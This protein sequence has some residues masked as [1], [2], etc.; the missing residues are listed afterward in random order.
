MYQVKKDWL[1]SI[2]VVC[3]V[4][5]A[6]LALQFTTRQQ[7][8]DISGY[9]RAD[10]LAQLLAAT[11]HQTDEQQ[12]EISKLR[13]TLAR[14]QASIAKKDELIGLVHQQ[15][16]SNR[17]ALG[18]VDVKGP[19]VAISIDDSRLRS[20]APENVEP[21]LLHDYDLWPLV[22]ELRAA[23]AEAISINGQHVAGNTAIRCAGSVINVNGFPIYPPLEILAIGKPETLY[24]ALTVPGGVLDHFKSYKFPVTIIKR[25]DIMI[26]AL[27]IE[28]KFLY[29]RPVEL[30]PRPPAP[31]P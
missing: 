20:E 4:L 2:T 7:M 11:R 17:I 29:A 22:N 27:D 16:G 3:L 8:G 23:G 25:P 10:T 15:L 12:Q 14:Y 30:G 9:R 6:M 26:K 31:K 28:P 21:F 5:G 1:L 13:W 24:G 18:L 19:G